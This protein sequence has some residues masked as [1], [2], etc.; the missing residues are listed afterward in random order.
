MASGLALAGCSPEWPSSA[1]F[2]LFTPPSS[3][4]VTVESNPPGAEARTSTGAVC[5]TPC[6]MT[7]PIIDEFTVTY[8]LDGY[9]PQTIPVRET[10][11]QKTALI[12]RTPP[13]LEPNPS[14]RN[15]SLRRR[16]RRLPSRGERDQRH[17]DLRHAFRFCRNGA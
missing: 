8:T 12:D 16:S 2:D 3:V 14:W 9:L 4:I 10:P 1:S 6:A 17:A 7:V 5:L 11:A 15:S 13:R